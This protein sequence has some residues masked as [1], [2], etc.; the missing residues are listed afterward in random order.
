MFFIQS[1][2][3]LFPVSLASPNTDER[4]EVH[5]ATSSVQELSPVEKG[6]E[7]P[8]GMT[9]PWSRACVVTAE[10]SP[11]YS[12]VTLLLLQY[13]FVLFVIKSFPT[14]RSFQKQLNPE[15]FFFCFFVRKN[16]E[17]IPDQI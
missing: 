5:A 15:S 2:P 3:P 4:E 11:M 16:H 7:L 8:V 12:P 10:P 6:K 13:K 14:E 9:Y 1:C 17:I